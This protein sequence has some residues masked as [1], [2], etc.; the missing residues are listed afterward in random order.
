MA[1]VSIGNSIRGTKNSVRSLKD[2]CRVIGRDLAFS[3]QA[4]NASITNWTP[5]GGAP[6]AP[7]AFS[8]SIIRS[9]TQMFNKFKI[10]RIVFHYIT[11]SSTAQAGDVMFYHEKNRTDSF[12]DFSNASFLPFVLSDADTVIG[13]Q[14]TNHSVE[15]RP[16]DAYNST[17]YGT[18]SDINDESSGSI[19]VFSKTP[20]ANSPGYV[21][22]DYDISF[23]ELSLNPRAGILPNPRIPWYMTSFGIGSAAIT[24][25]NI[26]SLPVLGPKYDGNPATPPSGVVDGEI[27]KVILDVTN[28]RTLSTWTNC[29]PANLIAFRGSGG[30]TRQAYTIDDGFTCFCEYTL[31]SNEYRFYPTLTAAIA[32]SN[33]LVFGVSATVSF[34]LSC[35]ISLVFNRA[36]STQSAY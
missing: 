20:T 11:S 25:G 26:I 2:G 30:D 23:K 33:P 13:P 3:L 29:T 6:L 28:A 27:Y 35:W 5:I 4:T 12:P 15:L 9:Y 10:N 17:D 14:W 19:F 36:Q 7:A 31:A 32:D 1:P 8:S 24:A 22:M 16:T 34:N 18:N 21:L